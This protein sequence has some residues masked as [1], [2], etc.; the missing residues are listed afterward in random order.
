MVLQPFIENS[1]WHGIM[2]KNEP[3]HIRI[4]I[5]EENDLLKCLIE[6][7]G[8][9]RELAMEMKNQEKSR[10]FGLKITEERLKLFGKQKLQEWIQF[11]D[12]KD[13]RNQACG[14]RVLVN[15]PIH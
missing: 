8:V 2:N 4:E 15:I 11:I 1:I 5:S 14:T 7:D 12:L 3:G 13:Q 10:S 9:G 6:D